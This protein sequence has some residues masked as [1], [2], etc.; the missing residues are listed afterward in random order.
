MLW[1]QKNNKDLV[2][3]SN[4]IYIESDH[5]ENHTTKNKTRKPVFVFWLKINSS[6]LSLAVR[7]WVSIHNQLHASRKWSI[8]IWSTV[9][10]T[11]THLKTS[12]NEQMAYDQQIPQRCKHP[13]NVCCLIRQTP[14]KWKGGP[15]WPIIISWNT[16]L[17]SRVR[18]LKRPHSPPMNI[19]RIKRAGLQTLK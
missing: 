15:I 4:I 1:H 18:I 13:T 6:H 9:W 16:I 5:L 3:V 2:L 10:T 8:T 14:E 7:S 11:Y 17:I 19:N 12:P